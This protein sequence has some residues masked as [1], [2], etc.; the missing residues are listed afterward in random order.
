MGVGSKSLDFV[1]SF[2][3]QNEFN[4]PPVVPPVGYGSIQTQSQHLYGMSSG[5]I[6]GLSD[7]L[8]LDSDLVSKYIDAED[9]DDS[10]LISSAIEIYSEDATQVDSQEHKTV[11]IKCDDGAIKRELEDLIFKRLNIEDSVWRDMRTLAKYGNV[12]NEIVAKDQ[13]GVIALNYLAPPT[14][15]RIE[16]PKEIGQM[17]HHRLDL[18]SDAL[19]FIYDPMG[20]FRTTTEQFIHEMNAR[21]SGEDLRYEQRSDSVVFESWEMVHMR[22][23]GRNP[24]SVYG[25]GIGASAR[26][27]F[28]RLCLLEDSIVM[29]RITRAPS[30]YAFYV[31]VSSIPPQETMGYLNKVKQSLKK[32]KFVNPQNQKQDLKFDPLS[33]NEDFFLPV[34]DGKESTRVESLAGPVYDQIEDVKFFE[35]KLFAALKVPKPFLTYEE[36]T[37]KTHLSAEDVRFARSVLRLQREYRSGIKKVCRVHLAAKGINPDTVDFDVMMTVPSSIFELAQ[38]EIRSAELELADKFGAWAPK[39]W[40]M[41]NILNFSDDQIKEMEIMSAVEKQAGIEV[42]AGSSAGSIDRALSKRGSPGGGGGA[43]IEVASWNHDMEKVLFQG[44]KKNTESLNERILELKSKDKAFDRRF[45]EISS[46]MKEIRD[47]MRK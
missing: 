20:Q 21:S 5:S 31:D 14:V 1:R 19:G 2:F 47:G 46:F 15:R 38:L 13:V 6:S 32:Q 10:P 35:N 29:H 36:S 25:D 22:L 33:P 9:Q 40:I 24:L 8:R 7:V 11:W 34:R 45:G 17:A 16:V 28:K 44:M 18:Q 23:I 4:R 42:Q 3:R 12:F 39:G 27:I 37:A 26:W 43:G 30:R 41:R